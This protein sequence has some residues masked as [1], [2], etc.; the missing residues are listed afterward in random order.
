[1]SVY[2]TGA[3]DASGPDIG[4][5]ILAGCESGKHQNLLSV[6]NDRQ[7]SDR[8]PASNLEFRHGSTIA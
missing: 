5:R 7:A 3:G 6:K 1:M 8:N 2:F 4:R